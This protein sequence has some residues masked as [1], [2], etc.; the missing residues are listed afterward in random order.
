MFWTRSRATLKMPKVTS[1][2]A[3]DCTTLL[4]E[5][6]FVC[7]GAL[8]RATEVVAGVDDTRLSI[9]VDTHYARG[10]P[11]SRC[12]PAGNCIV[13]NLGYSVFR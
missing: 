2:N 6:C 13:A 1:G 11:C 8:L 3:R 7:G 10:V 4:V 9:G 5:L 12:S